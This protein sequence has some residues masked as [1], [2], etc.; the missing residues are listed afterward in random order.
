MATRK[1]T[2]TYVACITVP[3]PL[4]G[5]FFFLD[6]RPRGTTASFTE[7]KFLTPRTPESSSA[8]CP[9]SATALCG[10]LK[11]DTALTTFL[12][13]FVSLPHSQGRLGHPGR[14]VGQRARVTPQSPSGGSGVLDKKRNHQ[15]LHRGSEDTCL[16]IPAAWTYRRHLRVCL[17][18]FQGVELSTL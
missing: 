14:H 10:F 3:F 18:I 7:I 16:E 9:H 5:Q 6:K 17:H 2:I 11:D 1:L 8:N 12:K 13:L 4:W 15:G